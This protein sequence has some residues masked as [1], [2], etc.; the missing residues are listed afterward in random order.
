MGIVSKLKYWIISTVIL[1]V[2]SFISFGQTYHFRN[3]NPDQGLPNRFVYTIN[4]DDKG[5]I[6]IGT[7]NGLTRFDGFSFQTDAKVDSAST[8]NAVTSRSS[9]DK[10][11][12]FGFS[13]GKVFCLKNNNF[14]EI[15]GIDAKQIND[16]IED[17]Q[18]RIIAVSQM[19]GLF[20]IDP[21]D[22][23]NVQK[24][25]SPVDYNLFS[26]IFTATGDLLL[27]TQQG[28]V[29]S[30]FHDD[31]LELIDETEELNFSKVQAIE[32]FR[33]GNQ[34][35]IGTEY[36]GL[37]MA[38]IQNDSIRLTKFEH[39]LLGGAR[40]Q[41]IICDGDIVWVSTFENG[42]LKISFEQGNN[43][44]LEVEQFNSEAGLAGNDVKTLYK[45]N[46]GNLWMGLYGSGVSIL[47]S[48]AYMFLTPGNGSNEN[49]IVTLLGIDSYIFAGSQ[50]G[51]YKLKEGSGEVVS[52]TDLSRYA[53]ISKINVYRFLDEGSLLIGTDGSGVY[54]QNPDGKVSQFFRSANNLENY[55]N[56]IKSDGDLVWLATH[57]GVIEINTETLD[58]RRFTTTDMLPHNSINQ[59]LPDGTGRVYVATQGNRLYTI[60][61]VTGVHS[62]KAV[63]YGGA[64]IEFQA[65]TID[66]EGKIWVS[67]R[68]SGVFCFSGDSVWNIS[69][70]NGLLNDYCS[71]IMCDNT[72]RIWIG[73]ERGFSVYDQEQDQMR[74]F[75]DILIAGAECNK[76]AIYET[77]SGIVLIGTSEGL[78]IYDPRKDL[79][80]LNPPV[81][82][83][84]SVTIDNVPY[85]LQD[86]YVLPYKNRYSLQIGIIG[87][88]Y[89]D[90]E[91][92]Y[93]KFRL[94]NYDNDWSEPTYNR[95]HTYKLSDGDYRFRM[96]SYNF[97]GISDNNEAGFDLLIKKPVW[98]MWWF[99][100]VVIILLSGLVMLIISIRERAQRKAK[101]QLENELAERTSE[102]IEQKEEIEQKS[103]E[104]TDS[105]N[106]AQ[107][108]QASLLPPLNKLNELFNGA[109]VF[110]RPRDIVS[111][112]FYWFDRLDDE[113]VIVVCADSTGH[114]VPG[115]FMSMIG[116]AL[117]QEIIVRKEITRPSEIL[118][119]LD[120][121]ISSTLN[122]GLDESKTSDG[123]DMV[124]CEY[125]TK[126]RLLR[127]ASAM[128]PV[129]LVMD[130]EQY[131]IRGNK[132][133][134]GGEEL[135]E[136]YFDDQ[137]YYLKENDT[138]YMF[139]DGYPD[140]FGG[141]AGKK[142][143]IIRLKQLIDEIQDLKMDNQCIKVEDYF[144]KWKGEL[145]QVDD[146]LFMAVK[147]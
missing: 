20:R 51:Y 61:P 34:Y 84:L 115:A 58:S 80:R 92:V 63:I 57:S 95:E 124:V 125:N 18:N 75:V 12:F 16:I 134:I 46:E 42:T 120:K 47:G 127:F 65:H 142:L 9:S 52:Y 4:Q 93:Y 1:S 140:Q 144:D 132:S 135:F 29:L 26:A 102:V 131:Y 122:Q 103:R 110:Y 145:D 129:I 114:G 6:W 10:S 128:R 59:I 27:G 2:C 139:S 39:E 116:S 62:G 109:F 64:R 85:A 71:S 67:T 41:S 72:G 31:V 69:S 113:R 3:Y 50:Q 108:I 76:N 126:T 83:I 25:A 60:D 121:E 22:N 141:K 23:Y 86:S 15:A 7:G 73:H 111:G 146:V 105:I 119:T 89:S 33:T 68:G 98:R 130:G 38:S 70:R 81:S 21:V 133:S 104:I 99:I 90:P 14:L 48:D 5:F 43:K 24:L 123:M 30:R 11:L 100:L 94:D 17:P 117:I 53:G 19:K 54:V 77:G 49:N 32:E 97:D 91:K 78:M 45:D 79:F 66:S 147:V 40:V 138:I 36:D 35:L 8:G 74:T 44:L 96:I 137:E 87:L 82:N 55:I 13:D 37:F 143:K 118:A 136:K 101:Q 112:D 107:R 106:Y 88:Y 28:L 56:D